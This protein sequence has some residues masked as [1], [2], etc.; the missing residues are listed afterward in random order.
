MKKVNLLEAARAVEP[1]YVYQKI[2]ELNGNILSVVNVENR[3]LDFHVHESSDE[4]FYVLEGGFQLETEE[5]L[6]DVNAGEFVIV[7]R[8]VRHRPVVTKLTR[9]LMV[10]FAGT[11]NKENSGALYEEP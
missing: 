10:E 11:L 1:L 3:T 4:L 8:G 5:G 9:F 6:T 7:P 2:G